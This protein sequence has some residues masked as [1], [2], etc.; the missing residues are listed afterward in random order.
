ML[1][2]D[3]IKQKLCSRPGQIV[4]ACYFI[5]FLNIRKIVRN[6]VYF[7]NIWWNSVGLMLINSSLLIVN[8]KN[9]L[10]Y[11]LINIKYRINN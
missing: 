8:P 5:I 11:R 4:E 10:Y 6:S 1:F 2:S 9:S 7:T 3:K